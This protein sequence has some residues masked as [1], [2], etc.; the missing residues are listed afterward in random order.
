[1]CMVCH[2]YFSLHTPDDILHRTFFH[3][4]VRHIFFGEV[5]VSVFGS[6]LIRLLVFLLL[7]FKYYLPILDNN[8]SSAVSFANIF[9][10]LWLVF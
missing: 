10:S 4:L 3:M 8:P 7:G 6:L 1:M 9:P 5:S 2:C